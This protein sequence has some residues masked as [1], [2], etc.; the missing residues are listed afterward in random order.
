MAIIPVLEPED[1][2]R[3]DEVADGGAGGVG[4]EFEAAVE[5]LASV[6][7]AVAVVLALLE[8]SALREPCRRDNLTKADISKTARSQSK[9]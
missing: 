3:V 7:V 6:P 4:V 2:A 9:Q 1:C 5:L 8:V